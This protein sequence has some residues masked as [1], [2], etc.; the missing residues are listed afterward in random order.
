ML[1]T[2][3]LLC[4]LCGERAQPCLLGQYDVLSCV[5]VRK[6]LEED[7][8][9]DLFVVFRTNCR[10]CSSSAASMG[11]V[12]MRAHGTTECTVSRLLSRLHHNQRTL[13]V[14]N[15]RHG[16]HLLPLKFTA[17]SQWTHFDFVSSLMRHCVEVLVFVLSLFSYI[18]K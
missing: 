9:R 5:Q 11:S 12:P 18:Y 2:A 10:R 1:H 3:A 4:Q 6:E 14:D 13:V 16:A 15:D 7:G 8:S 17:V